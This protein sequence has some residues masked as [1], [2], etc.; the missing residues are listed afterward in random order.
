MPVVK[1]LTRLRKT[2]R[3]L[4]VA[5]LAIVLSAAAVPAAGETVFVA[6]KKVSIRKDRQFYAPTVAEAVFR[7][8]LVV[9]A[10][11]KDWVR[12][13]SPGSRAGF[14]SRPPPRRP[15]RSPR[16][17][18]PAGSRRTTWRSRA[19]VSIP[20]SSANTQGQA[21]GELRRGRQDGA[22]HG[23]RESPGGVPAGGQPRPRGEKRERR[24]GLPRYLAAALLLAVAAGCTTAELKD[25]ADKT[26]QHGRGD[27][28]QGRRAGG[29][30]GDRHRRAR[31]GGC[32]DDV[33]GAAQGFRGP[34]AAGGV[35]HRPR[36]RRPHPRH[37]PPGRKTRRRH[38][39]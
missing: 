2:T 21:P 19:R 11:E 26:A 4:L 3:P 5:C 30:A 25:V 10:R 38:A 20:P 15:C 8:R 36:G 18:P 24:P 22:A 28:G 37:L 23:V 12:V 27:Q 34:H 31:Q 33:E 39:T 35:L 6:V 16:R 7:D 13:R 1:G 32:Q 17:M 9:L 14:T 29:R